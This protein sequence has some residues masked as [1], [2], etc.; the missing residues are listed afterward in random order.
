M[1]TKWNKESIVE[2]LQQFYIENN[3]IP[4]SRDFDKSKGLYPS[5]ETIRRHFGSWNK[6]LEAANLEKLRNRWT[7]TEIVEAIIHFYDKTGEPPKIRDFNNNKTYPHKDT[8]VSCFGSWHKA[9]EAAN[10]PASRKN[11][12]KEEIIEVIQQFYEEND[13]IPQNRD[14]DKSKSIYPSRTTVVR[15]FGSWNQAIQEAGFDPGSNIGYGT[16]TYGK[17]GYLYRSKAEAYFADTFLFGQYK[18]DIEPK[19]PK[20]YNKWYDWYVYEI[21]TYIELD[22]GIRPHAIEEKIKINETL[23]RQL[24]VIPTND[25]YKKDCSPLKL[26][27]ER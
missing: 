18:Y 6:A 13:R 22:G 26:T 9:L 14:F 16:N 15:Y 4:K 20:P 5:R 10:L 27:K 21:D 7:K 23:G 12:T 17:D 25:I 24:L 19:Y 1:T 8:V 11:W 3:F 2:I